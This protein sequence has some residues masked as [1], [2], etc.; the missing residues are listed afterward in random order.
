MVS[1]EVLLWSELKPYRKAG[2]R[3]RRQVPIGDYVVDLACHQ[4]RLVIEIDGPSHTTTPSAKLSDD[5]RDR[6]LNALGYRVLR[7]TNEDVFNDCAAVIETIL[8]NTNQERLA[9][10]RGAPPPSRGRWPAKPDGGWAALP[11]ESEGTS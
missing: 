1:A 9:N 3:I 5:R 10:A 11:P 6:V 8:A 4:N 2:A 7:F